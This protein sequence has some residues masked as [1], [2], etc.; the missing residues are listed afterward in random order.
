[1]VGFELEFSGISLAE[2]GTA[3]QTALGG[4]VNEKSAAEL[5]LHV[6]RLGD[7]GIELD[8]SYLKRKAEETERNGGD[9]SWLDTLSQ[10]AAMVDAGTLRPLEVAARERV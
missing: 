1:M 5:G 6:E 3:L 2:T 10:A 8:W 7:F 9:R 4:S